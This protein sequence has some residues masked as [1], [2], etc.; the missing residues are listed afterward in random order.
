MNH[1]A[2]VGVC[3]YKEYSAQNGTKC[4]GNFVGVESEIELLHMDYPPGNIFAE[5]HLHKPIL[6]AIFL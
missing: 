6:L 5:L 1:N 3:A 4:C 2:G